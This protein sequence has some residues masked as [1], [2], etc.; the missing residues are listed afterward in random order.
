VEAVD[1]PRAYPGRAIEALLG[2]E[3][4]RILGVALSDRSVDDKMRTICGI[5][6]CWAAKQ[7]P[8]WADLLGVSESAIRKTPFWRKDRARIF[9]IDG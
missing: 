4:Q 2:P 1:A 5:D 8:S 3:E 9:E 6:R 7:S